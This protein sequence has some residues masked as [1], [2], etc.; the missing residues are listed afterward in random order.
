[1][2]ASTALNL[3]E[4]C[5]DT[6]KPSRVHQGAYFPHLFV[7]AAEGLSC[8]LK[9]RIQSS[10]LKGIM[11]APSSPMVGHLLFADDSLLLFKANRENAMEIKDVLHLYC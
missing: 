8:L 7:L 10:V 2:N 11:V 1:M 4:V 5:L 9:S 3:L 6:F